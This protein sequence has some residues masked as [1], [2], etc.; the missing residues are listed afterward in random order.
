MGPC[1][2]RRIWGGHTN[3]CAHRRRPDAGKARGVKT[4]TQTKL[5]PHQ[6][7]EAIKR[8]DNGEAVRNIARSVRR[9]AYLCADLK[10]NAPSNPLIV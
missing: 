8:R 5:N 1:R 3:P 9:T 7:A 2:A 4:G 6:H 10:K